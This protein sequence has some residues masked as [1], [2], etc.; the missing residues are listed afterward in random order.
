M[1][2]E[3][4][5]FRTTSITSDNY[6]KAVKA[7]QEFYSVNTYYEVQVLNQDGVEIF[8]INPAGEKR[9]MLIEP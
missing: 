5:D 6:Q 4:G 7:A 2:T 3:C 1:D 8:G 9:K